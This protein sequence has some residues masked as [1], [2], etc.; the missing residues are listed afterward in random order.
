M[1]NC[2][3]QTL[4]TAKR[5]HKEITKTMFGKSKYSQDVAV[6][7]NKFKQISLL[8]DRLDHSFS[9]Y[10]YN[11]IIPSYAVFKTQLLFT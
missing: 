9:N 6:P 3:Y 10:R 5:V 4:T 11:K 8:C 2:V 1:V 7:S